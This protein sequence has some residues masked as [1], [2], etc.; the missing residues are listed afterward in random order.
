MSK[1]FV[2]GR[3]LAD[4]YPFRT[5]LDPQLSDMDVFGHLNNVSIARLYE[6]G[7]VRLH[8][9]LFGHD[10][11]A[12]DYPLKM[13]VAEQSTR[14]LAE[15]MFPASVDVLTGIER[16]GTSSYLMHQAMFQTGNCVGLNDC[17]MVMVVDKRPHSIP[18]EVRL[19]MG[20]FAC[21]CAN[22]LER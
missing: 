16:V 18:D 17:Q 1:S 10:C 2:R 15:A 5:R 21:V 19:R 13:V 20:S 4:S 9:E 6:N 14:F 22:Q 7:R 12:T 8:F 3:L 11:F